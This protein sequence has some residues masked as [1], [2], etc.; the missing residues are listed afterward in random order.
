MV[1]S[2]RFHPINPSLDYRF[3]SPTGQIIGVAYHVL[4]NHH[5]AGLSA[6]LREV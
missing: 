2:Y 5:Y 6:I 1:S 3:D 4:E